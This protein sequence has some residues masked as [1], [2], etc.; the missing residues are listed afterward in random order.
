MSK[1]DYLKRSPPLGRAS[2]VPE[3]ANQ[4]RLS[5]QSLSTHVHGHNVVE[6]FCLKLFCGGVSRVPESHGYP[7]FGF[8]GSIKMLAK[9]DLL[10]LIKRDVV[11]LVQTFKVSNDYPSPQT[12]EAGSLLLREASLPTTSRLSQL[13]ARTS[14]TA[15]GEP[16]TTLAR[17]DKGEER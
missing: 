8:S 9:I 5:F 4:N 13:E 16:S 2:R 12:K 14:W 15:S 10:S 3:D 7:C 11:F 6:A 1:A 17:D